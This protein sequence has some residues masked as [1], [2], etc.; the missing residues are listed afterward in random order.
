MR[1]VAALCT[2]ETLVCAA[3]RGTKSSSWSWF[4]DG[5]AL[6][7]RASRACNFPLNM[8]KG[9]ILGDIATAPKAQ[10][11]FEEAEWLE[12]WSRYF[13]SVEA[14]LSDGMV[15]V[16]C[17]RPLAW[18]PRELAASLRF[19]FDLPYPD[20]HRMGLVRL[21]LKSFSQ[22]LRLNLEDV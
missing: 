16:R 18:H 14:G 8:E 9:V 10:K 17:R 7:Q 12:L 20:G 2:P 19:E 15:T 4:T 6:S 22:R 5:E 11:F 3:A 1:I 13:G 21:A